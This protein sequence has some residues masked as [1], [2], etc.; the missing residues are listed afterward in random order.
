MVVVLTLIYSLLRRH[1][2]QTSTAAAKQKHILRPRSV[3]LCML[4]EKRT[5]HRVLL[6]NQGVNYANR[7][8]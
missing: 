5:V 6:H 4:R 2:S 7:I 1:A 8:Q 3:R